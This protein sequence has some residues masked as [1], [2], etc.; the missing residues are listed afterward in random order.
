MPP[1]TGSPEHWRQ[2]AEEMRVMAQTVTDP[3]AQRTMINIAKCTSTW[4]SG[5]SRDPRKTIEIA[6]RTIWVISTERPTPALSG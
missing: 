4:R 5:Q 1:I 2:R 3:E 6:D